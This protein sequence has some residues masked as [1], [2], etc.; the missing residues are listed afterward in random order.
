MILPPHKRIS[1]ENLNLGRFFLVYSVKMEKDAQNLQRA[2]IAI[3][4]ADK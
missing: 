3:K 4:E 2:E 1:M